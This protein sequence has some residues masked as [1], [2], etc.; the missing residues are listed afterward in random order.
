MVTEK[1]MKLSDA[2]M[3]TNDSPNSLELCVKLI[4]VGFD[5]GH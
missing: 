4:N 1:L 3:E 2:F 5:K